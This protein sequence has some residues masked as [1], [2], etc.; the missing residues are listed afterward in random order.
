MGVSRH[1][2]NRV[3]F[4]LFLSYQVQDP[5]QALKLDKIYKYSLTS[6]DISSV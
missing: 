2:V 3:V 4:H 1:L 6:L 5:E